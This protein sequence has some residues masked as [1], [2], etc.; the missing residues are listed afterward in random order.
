MVAVWLVITSKSSVLAVSSL[1]M[2]VEYVMTVGLPKVADNWNRYR[3][4]VPS[5]MESG[6]L[7]WRFARVLRFPVISNCM[8]A[9]APS[10]L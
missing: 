1:R 8:L 4:V 7:I 5:L 10:L 3:P 2:V 6:P 9:L